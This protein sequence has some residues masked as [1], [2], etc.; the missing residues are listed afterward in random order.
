MRELDELLTRYLD[1]RYDSAGADEKAAFS[2]LLTLS[3]PQLMRYLLQT[4][5]PAQEF[6]VVV[7]RI[8]DSTHA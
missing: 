6:S 5:E 8:L 2:R 1:T 4:E 3:D 7:R